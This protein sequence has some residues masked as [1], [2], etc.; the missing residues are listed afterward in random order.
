MKGQF[1]LLLIYFSTESCNHGN[2]AQILVSKYGP[3]MQM[4]FCEMHWYCGTVKLFCDVQYAVGHNFIISL[5]MLSDTVYYHLKI[6]KWEIKIFYPLL[7]MHR[8]T[9]HRKVYFIFTI[10]IFIR[11]LEMSKL[12]MKPFSLSFDSFARLWHSLGCFC[13]PWA[14]G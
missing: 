13:T 1:E 5:G 14:L 10:W 9:A 2:N 7:S 6:W 3:F 12:F 4:I 8:S 11:I